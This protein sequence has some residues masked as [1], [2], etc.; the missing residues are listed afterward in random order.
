MKSNI[1]NFIQN[2][3]YNSLI[4]L[5]YIKEDLINIFAF[6]NK[7]KQYTIAVEDLP[8]FKIKIKDDKK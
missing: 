8:E 2:I 7:I 5:G 4:K 1:N 3:L 6:S